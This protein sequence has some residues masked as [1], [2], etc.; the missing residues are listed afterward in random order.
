[1]TA[2]V[3]KGALLADRFGRYSGLGAVPQDDVPL[4]G[5]FADLRALERDEVHLSL[6]IKRSLSVSSGS[7]FG[8]NGPSLVLGVRVNSSAN[9]PRAVN[10]EALKA[11]VPRNARRLDRL[12]FMF[13]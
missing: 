10:A 9:A 12:R 7:L 5:Q 6:M 1:M 11:S 2:A 13:M 8:K 4:H 3:R